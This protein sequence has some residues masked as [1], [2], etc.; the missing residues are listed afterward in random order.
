M[1]G[2]EQKQTDVFLKL[3]G[4][5]LTGWEHFEMFCKREEDLKYNFYKTHSVLL[6]TSKQHERKDVSEITSIG[7]N[8]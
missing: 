8:Y 3:G 5:L 4:V 2:S 6:I 7:T 1:S